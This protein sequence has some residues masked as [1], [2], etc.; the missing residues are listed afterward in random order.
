MVT[1]IES[2]MNS[3]MKAKKRRLLQ[4]RDGNRCALCFLPFLSG[5]TP[6]LDHVIPLS[7]GGRDAL[8]NLQLAHRKCNNFRSNSKPAM[9]TI[10]AGL[11]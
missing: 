8:W 10:K 4:K 11:E 1:K 9:T 7:D 3:V 2:R 6:T 5:E